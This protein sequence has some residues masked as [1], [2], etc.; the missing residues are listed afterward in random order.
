MKLSGAS[1]AF[2]LLEGER[3]RLTAAD[4]TRRLHDCYFAAYKVPVPPEALQLFSGTR[5]LRGMDAV[6]ARPVTAKLDRRAQLRERAAL[7]LLR[8]RIE[9]RFRPD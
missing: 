3:D 4:L 6:P 8:S 7:E 5:E 9:R 2:Q 1:I